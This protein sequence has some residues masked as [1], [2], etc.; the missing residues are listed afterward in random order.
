MPATLLELQAWKFFRNDL[1]LRYKPTLLLELE[2][3]SFTEIDISQVFFK[4]I[5]L[6]LINLLLIFTIFRTPVD[7]YYF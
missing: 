6:I 2:V 4:D 5:T 3:C 7:G 1:F